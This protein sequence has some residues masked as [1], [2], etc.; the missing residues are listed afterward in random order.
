MEWLSNF[1]YAFIGGFARIF[2]TSFI[3]WMIGIVG[4]L[5]MELFNNEEFQFR[6]YLQKV[7]KVLLISFQIAVYGSVVVGLVLLFKT[8]EYLTYTL[9]TIDGILLSILYISLR[10][11]LGNFRSKN[12]NQGNKT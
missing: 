1:F 9:V 7:W 3:L 6:L 5:F 2:I 12:S 10:R 11:R 4:L 8:K